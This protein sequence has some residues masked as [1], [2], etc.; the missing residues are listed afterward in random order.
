MGQI[1]TLSK[2]NGSLE[3]VIDINVREIQRGEKLLG[4]AKEEIL[5]HKEKEKELTLKIKDIER[6]I[7]SS[8][9]EVEKEREKLLKE[10]QEF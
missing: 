4:E 9:N 3:R 10:K 1:E 2:E 5:S 7:K 6:K 8:E